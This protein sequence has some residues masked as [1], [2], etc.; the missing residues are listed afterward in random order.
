M[1]FV[2]VLPSIHKPYTDICLQSMARPLHRAT[3]VVDNT[4]TNRGVP[5]SWN[6]GIDNMGGAD[7]LIIISAACRFSPLGGMDFIDHLDTAGHPVVEA[8]YVGWHLIAFHRDVIERVGRF[9]EN[10]YP[11]YWEDCDYARRIALAYDLEPPFWT[12][13]E[14]EVVLESFAHGI[15]LAGIYIDPVPLAD[16]YAE[17]WGGM[18]SFET[19]DTPFD[20]GNR[21]DWWP[22]RVR[23]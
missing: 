3:T 4:V 12:K 10:F 18:P 23:A 7:W 15:Q 22:D 1:S 9:D 2:A 11:A 14:C 6:H 17:K 5:A 13:V 19:F 20:S 8:R 21:L 16:Y